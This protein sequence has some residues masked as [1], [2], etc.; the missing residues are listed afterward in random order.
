VMRV[1]HVASEA[2]PW[3]Q[4]GG[5]GDVVGA[6]P[7]ALV[8]EGGGA[9]DV[10]VLSPMYRGVAE[11]LASAGAILEPPIERTVV[12]GP[13]RVR[14][15]LRA[16]RR[17][18]GATHWFVD[19]PDLYDRDGLYTHGGAG[20]VDF[21]DNHVRFAVLSQAAVAFGADLCGG[22]VDIVHGH[23]WQTGVAMTYLRL[24]PAHAAT[25]AVFTIHN[26]AFRGLF[27]KTTVHDLGLPWSEFTMQRLEFF[28]QVSL[29]KAGLAHADLVTTV[30][31]SYAREILEP[32]AG[33]GLDGFLRHEVT[34]LV[35][36][37]NAIDDVAWDPATDPAIAAPFSADDPAG[38][39]A[40]RRALADDHDLDLGPD[41]V[42]A[43]VVSRLADQKGVDLIADLVPEL[44]GLDVRLIVLG[45]GDP[46]LEDRFRWL[47]R[48]FRDHCAVTIGFDVARA[49]RI[50]AGA[51]VF[52]MPSR[53][54][55]C[56]IGQLYA[57][58]YGAVPIVHAV[59][60][61]RDTVI[62]P[63]DDDLALGRGTGFA[64]AHADGIGLRWGLARALAMYRA[65][66]AGW[67]SLVEAAMRRDSSWTPSARAYL[68]HYRAVLAARR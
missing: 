28:D 24:D 56:G 41:T 59:G 2:A 65:R 13:H 66:R 17:D 11:R 35:G 31:P 49:R 18:R 42:V 54:E 16:L 27:A 55:P 29:L 40:C 63:G 60:G 62:D 8:R 21:A 14:V 43:A 64:F 37:V 26:L 19:A 6:L 39:A 5:L 53:F 47:A 61:L 52:L 32:I 45:A 58:R 25:G 15:A 7:D 36:I 3:S 12:V 44:F 20:G 34:R 46:V 22:A 48:V 1:L 9:V 51:D 10:A 50:Y 33:E 67:T 30:S 68:D 57:M 23:D 4:T 38:K